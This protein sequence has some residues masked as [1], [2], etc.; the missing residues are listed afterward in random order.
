MPADPKPES[1]AAA[2]KD[3]QQPKQ[4]AAPKLAELRVRI[5]RQDGEAQPASRRWEEFS[6]ERRRGM[7]VRDALSMIRDRPVT[8]QGDRV[9]PV[10]FEESCGGWTCGSCTIL[11]QEH[12][13]LSCKARVDELAPKGQVITLQ[14]LS[15]FPV[16]R[17][18]V[19]DRSRVYEI[20]RGR[21]TW[22]APGAQA[23]HF[24]PREAVDAR[25]QREL[26]LIAPCTGCDAC[27]EACPQFGSGFMGART[28]NELRLLSLTSTVQ[29]PRH[30]ESAMGRDGVADCGHAQN[31]VEVCPAGI[32]LVDSIQRLSWDTTKE[33]IL[34]WLLGR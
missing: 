25:Q 2:E 18:L 5:L 28:L 32:P 22:Q 30:V 20:R 34:G 7:T 8:A 14:P 19:V 13:Q 33:L 24:A 16:L 31:C 1:S 23:S 4:G 15:K 27:L 17:D 3:T 11:I 29:A 21:H 9:S 26:S 10:C 12:A 6:I